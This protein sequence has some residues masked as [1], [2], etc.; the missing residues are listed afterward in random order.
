MLNSPTILYCFK[1]SL[2][3]HNYYYSIFIYLFALMLRSSVP[4]IPKHKADS[5]NAWLSGNK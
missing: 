3:I 1:Y 2:F 5:P 4:T